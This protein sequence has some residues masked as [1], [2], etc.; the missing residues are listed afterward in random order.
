M[1]DFRDVDPRELRVPPSRRQGADPA[2]LHRQIALIGRS[3]AGMPAPWV[4]EGTDGVL[5]LYNGVTRAT[6][7]AKL[8][9]GTLIRV[10]V[11]GKLP[12]AFAGE[13]KIGDLLP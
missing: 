9:V 13:P 1:P 4:Y 2:K 5:M 8:L 12:K 6:R 10:E 7:L 3:S 11:I